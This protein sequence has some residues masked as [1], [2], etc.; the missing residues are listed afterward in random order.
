MLYYE[1]SANTFTAWVGQPISGIRH[2]PNIENLWTTQE[3]TAKDLY[4][5]E[6]ADAVAN[7]KTVISSTVK[8]IGGVVKYVNTLIDTPPE[9]PSNF[10]LSD[11]Q[12][13]LGLIAGG[14]PL[15]SIEAAIATIPD[16][17]QRHAA[18]IWWDRS[19]EV[20]CDHP[21]TQSLIA[22]VGITTQQASAMW[23]A[24]KNIDS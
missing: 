11:R 18:E 12:L 14:I 24:A 6:S 4:V 21:M 5:P 15:A 19:V 10:P 23:L 17:T 1:Q 9:S 16:A 20:H 2:P 22:L 7:G 8:R 3:L 13:R